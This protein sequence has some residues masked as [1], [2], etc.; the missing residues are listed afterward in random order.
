MGMYVDQARQHG[1]ARQIDGI[2]IG[3]AIS[4]NRHLADDRVIDFD[5]HI[6]EQCTCFNVEDRAG[7]DLLGGLLRTLYPSEIAWQATDGV[8]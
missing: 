5:Q 4:P 7:E 1:M 2:R 8:R 3:A 6:T